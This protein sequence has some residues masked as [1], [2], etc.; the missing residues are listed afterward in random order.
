MHELGIACA[1]VEAAE[2]EARKQ[3]AC[4][5][6][7]VS[8]R[9]G[10][11]RLVCPEALREGFALAA[12]GTLA[13]GAALH[14]TAV[15]MMLE[16]ADC[17]CKEELPDWAFECPCCHS[18]HVRLSGGNDLELTSIELEVQGDGPCCP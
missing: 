13:A 3:N 16:C 14:L 8:C 4:R 6:L 15:G 5:V 12:I 9:I 1:L 2:A 18:V 11:I 7:G 17:A 10:A